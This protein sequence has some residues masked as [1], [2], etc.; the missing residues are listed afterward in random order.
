MSLSGVRVLVTG[1]AGF[2]GHHLAA[3][4]VQRGARV[5]VLDDLS[6][7]RRARLESLSAQ[8][9][10]VVGS[11]TDPR[12]VDPAMQDVEIVFHQAAMVSVPQS[13]DRPLD[14]QHV[15]STGT[16]TVLE[17]ARAAG[18]RRI[19][20]AAS[21]SAYGPQQTMPLIETMRP[22][23]IS[24]YAA[25]KLSGEFHCAVYASAFAR[26]TVSLRYFN[27]FGPGQDPKSQ[28]G[29]LIP[30]VATRMLRGQRPLI[31]GDGE[32]TRDFC[33]V[34]NVV[35]AN[36]LAAEAPKLSGEVL[37]I[38]C[39]RRV[40]V[41]DVVRLTNRLL[42]TNIPGDLQPPR[43]GDVHDSLADVSRARA[44]IGY[45][46][47]MHFEEGLGRALEYYRTLV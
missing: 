27:V 11:I 45:E 1:G 44:V 3:A 25:S 36:L 24:P 7:G 10:L 8:I 13:M 5:R 4:L 28:Y 15:N 46:P 39:G 30:T 23:P 37:N 26:E 38:A 43:A 19:V 42:G 9:E 16:L 2:I 6:S 14:Y 21:S 22:M 20:Y 41:N 47:K 40:S 17:A 34:A 32:Q 33:F 35:E 18:V 12:A 31:Y 29:A